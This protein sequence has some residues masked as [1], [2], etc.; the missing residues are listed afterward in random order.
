MSRQLKYRIKSLILLLVFS[1]N[2][3]AGFACS[4]GMNMGYNEGHHQHGK[5]PVKASTD[6]HH[7]HH[8]Q[9]PQKSESKKEHHGGGED[10]CGDITKLNLADKSVVNSISLQVPVFFIALVSQF[11]L[12][13]A[14]TF[15]LL[16][17]PTSYSLRRSW[18]LHD[19]TDLRIVIQSFQI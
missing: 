19:H 7:D 9:E 6:H 8:D 18:N 3:L 12:P 13:E 17:N 16:N 1:I 10:C 14:T 4:I 2:T 5:E 11:I 15:S